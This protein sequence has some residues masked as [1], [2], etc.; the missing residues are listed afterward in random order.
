VIVAGVRLEMLITVVAVGP[1]PSVDR[2]HGKSCDGFLACRPVDLT[3]GPDLVLLAHQTPIRA[4]IRAARCG[5]GLEGAGLELLVLE[6]PPAPLC[7]GPVGEGPAPELAP[8]VLVQLLDPS[9]NVAAVGRCGPGRGTAPLRGH[10]A[11]VG[12]GVRAVQAGPPSWRIGVKDWGT[13]RLVRLR[14]ECRARIQAIPDGR[15]RRLAACRVLGPSRG[16]RLCGVGS[17]GTFFHHLVSNQSNLLFSYRAALDALFVETQAP[18]EGW[19][20]PWCRLLRR[21]IV[22]SSSRIRHGWIDCCA[23]QSRQERNDCELP[24]RKREEV[25]VGPFL[26]AQN[27]T[28]GTLT[29]D[30]HDVERKSFLAPPNRRREAGVDRFSPGNWLPVRVVGSSLASLLMT[31]SISVV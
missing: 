24:L 17:E 16:L 28:L 19:G 18:H 8:T 9:R 7:L 5:S 23:H 29:E 6:A 1:A 25:N 3:K 20:P 21:R 10:R 4:I 31:D 22:Y 15:M 13:R 11:G 12:G 30:A 27:F 14:R 2:A 26:A